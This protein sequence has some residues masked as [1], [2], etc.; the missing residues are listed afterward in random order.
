MQ[1]S[2]FIIQESLTLAAAL[3]ITHYIG[4]NSWGTTWGELGYVYIDSQL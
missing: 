2:F 1:I 4:K 3:S